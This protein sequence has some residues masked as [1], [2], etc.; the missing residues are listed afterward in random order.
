MAFLEEGFLYSIVGHGIPRS[1][2]GME[3]LCIE[4]VK[5]YLNILDMFS[6]YLKI[7]VGKETSEEKTPD[8]IC[9][10]L[11]FSETWT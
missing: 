8:G 3:A 5:I 4:V 7:V 1:R 10:I 9:L 2:I 6:I 11:F